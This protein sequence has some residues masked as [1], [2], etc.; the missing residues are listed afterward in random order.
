MNAAIVAGAKASLNR[1]ASTGQWQSGK[2]VVREE[3]IV[4]EISIVKRI[5]DDFCGSAS[6][7]CPQQRSLLQTVTRGWIECIRMSADSLEGQQK[8]CERGKEVR[9][10]KYLISGYSRQYRDISNF[11][12]HT[13]C[14]DIFIVVMPFP[15][16]DAIKNANIQLF[17][18]RASSSSL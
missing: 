8:K 3:M 15:R 10:G 1:V 6:I 7:I 17:L 9:E 2:S 11:P 16:V 12:K 18:Y 4:K 14:P 13:S 5:I